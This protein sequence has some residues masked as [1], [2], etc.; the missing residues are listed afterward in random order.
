MSDPRFRPCEMAIPSDRQSFGK[1]TDIRW[2]RGTTDEQVARI[3]AARLQ[4]EFALA[5]TR[6][7]HSKRL[8]I[9]EYAKS[10]GGGYDRLA[11][12]LRGEVIMRLEDISDAERLLG[13]IVQKRTAHAMV[14]AQVTGAPLDSPPGITA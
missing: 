13:E 4:H 11:K 8:S 6:R 12:V 5:I 2:L 14:T 9:R 1:S 7:L 3:D 10:T